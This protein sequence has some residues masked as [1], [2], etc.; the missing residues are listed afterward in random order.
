MSLD[1]WTPHL[2]SSVISSADARATCR[3]APLTGLDNLQPPSLPSHTSQIQLLVHPRETASSLGPR[4]LYHL[5]A[6]VPVSIL[7]GTPRDLSKV[8]LYAP[9]S[10]AFQ[11]RATC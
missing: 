1:P 6:D 5:Y 2:L 9:H 11:F 4:V 10:Q 7:M 8:F 3:A